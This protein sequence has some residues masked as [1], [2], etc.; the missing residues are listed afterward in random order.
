MTHCHWSSLWNTYCSHS[1]AHLG[2]C[3][4]LWT[5]SCR[6]LL[7]VTQSPSSSTLYAI[8]NHRK[9]I[10]GENLSQNES[11]RLL[12]GSNSVISRPFL[13]PPWFYACE[14]WAQMRT[15][16]YNC[17]ACSAFFFYRLQL[18]E[19][20]HSQNTTNVPLHASEYPPG[21]IRSVGRLYTISS[22]NFHQSN[23]LNF[24]EG[25]YLDVNLSQHPARDLSS[26]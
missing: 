3:S 13:I 6:K 4:P 2:F 1:W 9:I 26:L 17:M 12:N 5:V 15:K 24:I 18:C 7:R 20:L 19:S 14:N 10:G 25:I 23:M 16:C 8:D 22:D 11:T 21:Q